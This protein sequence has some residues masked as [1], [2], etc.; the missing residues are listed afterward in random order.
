[1]RARYIEQRKTGVWVVAP[2]VI[3]YTTVIHAFAQQALIGKAEEVFE[4]MFRDY[5]ENGNKAAK[6]DEAAFNA[7]VNGLS[8]QQEVLQGRRRKRGSTKKQ[9]KK[10]GRDETPEEKEVEAREQL[11]EKACYHTPE[12][13][14][15]ILWRMEELVDKGYLDFQPSVWVYS[16]VLKAWAK[17]GRQD[18]PKRAKKILDRM[19]EKCLSGENPALQPNLIT[20][21]IVLD[22]YARAGQS[23]EALEMLEEMADQYGKGFLDN[24]PSTLSYTCCISSFGRVKNKYWIEP[25]E[26]EKVFRKMLSL[27]SPKLKPEQIC[28]TSLIDVYAKAAIF[29]DD[30][31]D[32]T[33]S[34]CLD[35][36]EELLIEML[37]SGVKATAVTYNTILKAIAFSKFD[38][39]RPVRAKK[40]LDMM[41]DRG[42]R[43]DDYTRSVVSDVMEKE[44]ERRRRRKNSSSS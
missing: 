43:A 38:T 10:E 14:E 5:N 16:S 33:P 34:Q 22:S 6:P 42:V 36:A 18:G 8:L 31:K 24:G 41:K 1:M 9:R 21:N 44:Q 19:K 15:Q 40:I 35:R 3:T 12:R 39:D 29:G 23:K 2:D 27:N 26:A 28:W 7:L 30:R 4:M 25:E 20:Y 37:D 13:A 32:P 11:E 17:S